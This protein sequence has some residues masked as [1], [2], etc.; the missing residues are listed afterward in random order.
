MI[1]SQSQMRPDTYNRLR[2]GINLTLRNDIAQDLDYMILNIE[3]E[4]ATWPPITLINIYN[5]KNPHPNTNSI[6]ERTA[7]CL[8]NHIPHHSIPTIIAG[9]WTMRNPSLHDVV[10]PPT[11][12]PS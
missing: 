6:H 10:T 4:G 5:Q 1:R 2:V 12:P 3:R 7:D 8:H 11:T 9:D